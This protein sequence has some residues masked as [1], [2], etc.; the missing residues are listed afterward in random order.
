MSGTWKN[1][2]LFEKYEYT[3]Q[4]AK[5]KIPRHILPI[6]THNRWDLRHSSNKLIPLPP[7]KFTF[8]SQ[9]AWGEKE[10]HSSLTNFFVNEIN[11]SRAAAAAFLC[12]LYSHTRAFRLFGNKYFVRGERKISKSLCASLRRVGINKHSFSAAIM[13]VCS[14]CVVI[15]CAF[16]FSSSWRE[17]HTW[18]D[19]GVPSTH[20]SIRAA[21]SKFVAAHTINNK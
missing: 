15:Y 13:R 11:F 2:I 19:R 14:F 7:Q 17:R 8:S 20:T 18:K 9:R 21:A 12:I 6:L 5:V 1:Y 10:F 3:A 16:I 4:K